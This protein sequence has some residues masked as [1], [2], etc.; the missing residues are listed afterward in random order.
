MAE[1]KQIILSHLSNSRFATVAE[2]STLLGLSTVSVRR[3]LEQLD[4]EGLVRRTRGG[5]LLS[6]MLVADAPFVAK[7]DRSAAE[8]QRIGAA[9]AE[10]VRDGQT[11]AL[12]AGTT[13]WQVARSLRDRSN[14]TVVTNSL[15]IAAEFVNSPDIRLVVTGGT[16]RDGSQ[17]LVGPT[18]VRTLQEIFVDHLFLG[19]DGISMTRGLTVASPEEAQV[20]RAMV[21]TAQSVTVVADHSKFDSIAFALVATLDEVHR[22]I[23]DSG[24]PHDILQRMRKGRAEILV[25]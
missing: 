18:A 1:C 14:L 25:V 17:A 21:R 4:T 8:K 2:L 24:L 19:V 3:Y 11:V 22:V 15:A 13:T 6:E 10:L 12:A 23:T 9:A 7:K 16:C 5:A 20:D